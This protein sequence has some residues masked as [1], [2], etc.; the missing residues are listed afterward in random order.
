MFVQGESSGGGLG[1]GLTLVQQLTELHGGEVTARSDGP[2][3]GSEFELRL[4]AAGGAESEL[5]ADPYEPSEHG[6]DP[7]MRVVVIDDD[8][9][10]RELTRA[11]LEHWGHS[12]AEAEDGNDGITLVLSERPDVAII[13]IGLGDI[14]G[15]EVARRL[16][17]EL[18]DSCP[19][20]IAMT[21]LGEP[22]DR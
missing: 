17:A 3:R 5:E 7:Q 12:V 1:I 21:G 19:R 9:D 22:R 6:E 2:G 18:G 10:V 14:E 20:L 15:Y 16:R 13:D 8:R 11:V 4:P